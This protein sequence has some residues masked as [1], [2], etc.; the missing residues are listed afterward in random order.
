MPALPD[1]LVDPVASLPADLI[2]PSLPD[3]LIEPPQASVPISGLTAEEQAAAGTEM[4][5]RPKSAGTAVG[6][7]FEAAKE[8][9]EA[10]PNLAPGTIPGA[11]LQGVTA[12]YEAGVRALGQLGEELTGKPGL[13]RDLRMIVDTLGIV[14]GA[15]PGVIGAPRTAKVPSLVPETPEAASAATAARV[16]PAAESISAATPGARLVGDLETRGTGALYSSPELNQIRLDAMEKLKRLGAT[17]PIVKETLSRDV[18]RAIIDLLDAGEV[19]LAPDIKIS[20]QVRDLLQTNVLEPEIFQAILAKNNVDPVRFLAEVTQ[21]EFGKAARL[22]ATQSARTLQSLSELRK[23]EMRIRA[24][25]GEQSDEVAAFLSSQE[26]G[27]DNAALSTMRRIGNV[28]RGA[29]V[30]QLATA[31][32]NAETSVA[33]VG[34]DVY[35]EGIEKGLRSVFAN[36]VRRLRGE[37]PID[38]PLTA[39]GNFVS[40]IGPRRAMEMA[41]AIAD[42][43]PSVRESLFARYASDVNRASGRKGVLGSVERAVDFVNFFNR[44]QDKML[45]SAVFSGEL[46]QRLAARGLNLDDIVAN[47]RIGSIPDDALKASTEKALEMTWSRGLG[48]DVISQTVQAWDRFATLGGRV[49]NVITPFARFMGDAIRFQYDYSPL[50]ATRLLS[51]AE[52]KGLASGNPAQIKTAARALAG[53]SF[54]Y[55]AYLLRNSSAAGPQWYEVN[56]PDGRTIDTRPFAPFSTYLFVADLIK[57][58]QEGT[59]LGMDSKSIAQGLIGVNFRAGAGLF[60]VDQLTDQLAGVNSL[61]KMGDIAKR[62]AGQVLAGFA[63]PFQTLKDVIAQFVPSERIMRETREAPLTGPIRTRIPFAGQGLPEVEFPTRTGAFERESPLLR[64]LTGVSLR[65]AP[66]PAETELGRLGFTRREILPPTGDIVF[67]RLMAKNLGPLVENILSKVVQ[68]PK[69][70]SLT[71]NFAKAEIIRNILPELRDIARAQSYM[72]DKTAEI[73]LKYQRLP[74]RQRA[75][76]ESILQ[77]KG[78]EGLLP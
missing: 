16:T 45:R 11:M 18:N 27:V 70:Q 51:P 52:L 75:L 30:S 47:N 14:T 73:R 67:D 2:A 39:L 66:N 35:V 22:S 43:K 49:P 24:L 62:Y 5:S 56:L 53:S 37:P 36:P 69:Y 3:D 68:A 77:E 33:R 23:A 78:Q 20:D 9:V 26:N 64:Q 32:R 1:D 41:K 38:E 60:L 12:A 31:V 72:Q 65:Q 15:S 58:Q 25:S 57:R 6:R 76:I 13:E 63:V 8:G 54:L 48:N 74:R 4:A 21:G 10:T 29:L 17:E 59:L 44:A 7:V 34:V 71:N 50:G 46:R 40:L 42:V 19:K 55:G 61:K 28:W